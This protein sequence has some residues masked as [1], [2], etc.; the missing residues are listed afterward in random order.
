MKANEFLIRGRLSDE[1]VPTRSENPY[2]ILVTFPYKLADTFDR[3]RLES[4]VID[5]FRIVSR[6][7]DLNSVNSVDT[8]IL[9]DSEIREWSLQDTKSNHIHMLNL[10][11][12]NPDGTLA[13][14]EWLNG[15]DWCM[16]WA[17][18]NR[19]D[20]ERI[21]NR[22]RKHHGC[23]TWD[24]NEAPAQ[25][26]DQEDTVNGFLD[27]LKF[28]GRLQAPQH[29]EHRFSG[30]AYDVGYEVQAAGFT[31][32]E[33]LIYYDDV[34]RFKYQNAVH[35]MQDLGINLQTFLQADGPNKGFVNTNK[36]I[37]GL[38]Q[39]LLGK[40][41][42]SLSKNTAEKGASIS[43]S[44]NEQL[45][46]PRAVTRMLIGAQQA[47]YRYADILQQWIGDQSFDTANPVEDHTL[48]VPAADDIVDGVL[49]TK[50]P[51]V[52][53]FSPDATDF[54][55]R[56]VWS[57]I[58]AYT[59]VPINEVYT[60]L[61]PHAI[62][63]R[64]LPTLVVRRNPLS[65][66]MYQAVR[67][68]LDAM[69]FSTVPRW[70]LPDALVSGYQLSRTDAARFNYVHVTPTCS[71]SSDQAKTEAQFRLQGA[72]I[73]DRASIQR[74]GLRPFIFKAAG[75]ATPGNET[76]A[77]ATSG[78]YT[79]FMADILM[80]GHLRYGGV[81]TCVGIQE[82]VQPGDNLV[83]H[84]MLLHI[85]S[86]AHRGSISANGT[87]SFT[88]SF[89][90]SHGIPLTTLAANQRDEIRAIRRFGRQQ[91]A[92]DP[93]ARSQAGA[94]LSTEQAKKAQ[95]DFEQA[96]DDYLRKYREPPEEELRTLRNSRQEL[97]L[98]GLVGAKV[99]SEKS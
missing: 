79:S 73:V 46:V 33:S 88:T 36:A 35:F 48:V 56:T 41:P 65:S 24:L 82:P 4:P 93:I 38:V 20:Y 74:H 29:G 25:T 69:P 42:G 13:L 51:L 78:R 5:G 77:M 64:L 34:I 61:R 70:V 45:V 98:I 16:F 39:I 55:M 17:F 30:G 52:D 80:D 49:Y 68:S 44:P 90:V 15:G 8:P 9:L 40:G 32:F 26:S 75:F 12:F 60:S 96:Y 76:E 67:D 94:K 1:P 84:G 7:D 97:A 53:Y 72:P 81:I 57:I 87:K 6:D 71:V 43:D 14:L 58:N 91:Q 11:L 83:F 62:S 21:K 47:D 37:P 31:E 18:D 95:E 3:G 22:L 50:K 63:G 27:G 19:E 92:P 89:M 59:N 85:E 10:H 28:I 54:K 23:R 2:W 66:D 99:R 86:V